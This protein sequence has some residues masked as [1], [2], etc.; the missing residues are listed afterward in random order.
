MRGR[1]FARRAKKMAE[2]TAVCVT[3]VTRV[4]GIVRFIS[5]IFYFFFPVLPCEALATGEVSA[6]PAAAVAAASLD[7]V[8]VV[9]GRFARE[10]LFPLSKCTLS[11]V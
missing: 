10:F 9:V 11:L 4:G 7:A 1:N 3:V 8:V 5:F 6:L 2:S